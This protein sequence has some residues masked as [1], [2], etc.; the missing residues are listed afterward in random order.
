[1]HIM[2]VD[3][4]PA[5]LES[6]RA[7]LTR[8]GHTVTGFHNAR[9]ALD[10]FVSD[11]SACSVIMVD[12]TLDGMSGEELIRKVLE[13]KPDTAVI[14]TSGYHPALYDLI[15]LRAARLTTLEKPFTPQMLIEALERLVPN[16]KAALG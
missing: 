15:E 2:V 9:A 6:L 14:A 10:C 4:E 8:I 16:Q 3:D 13:H 7:Y 11:P 1:M 5:L 12:L